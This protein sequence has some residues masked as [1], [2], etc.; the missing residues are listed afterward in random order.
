M[1]RGDAV[2]VQRRNALAIAFT[3]LSAVLTGAWT[4]ASAP[5]NAAGKASAEAQT[6]KAP[7]F[8][9]TRNDNGTITAEFES[10][11]ET[12]AIMKAA[13]AAVIEKAFNDKVRVESI[14]RLDAGDVVA[15]GAT[16][17]YFMLRNGNRRMN[18]TAFKVTGG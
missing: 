11:V 4:Q 12:D 17:M 5:A 13:L 16:A 2:T 14:R 7:P 9:W 8:T 18:V 1:S 10:D 3:L 15:E 6:V